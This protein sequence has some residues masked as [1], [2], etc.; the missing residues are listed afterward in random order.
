VPAL[1]TGIDNQE[2]LAG[3]VH[4]WLAYTLIGLVVLHALGALKHHIF[5]RDRTLQ[6]MLAR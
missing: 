4:L 1:R 6:R 5:D 3:T 2:D